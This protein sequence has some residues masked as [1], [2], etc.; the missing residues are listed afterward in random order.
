MLSFAARRATA[1]FLGAVVLMA[2]NVSVAAIPSSFVLFTQNDLAAFKIPTPACAAALGMQLQCDRA[3]VFGNLSSLNQ[4][5]ER[6]AFCNPKGACQQSIQALNLQVQKDCPLD[7]MLGPTANIA[8]ILRHLVLSSALPCAHDAASGANC[9]KQVKDAL[10][11]IDAKANIFDALDKNLAC[12]CFLAATLLRKPVDANAQQMLYTLR[13]RICGENSVQ[14]AVE[15]ILLPT[16]P[17]L[18]Y[19]PPLQPANSSM[20]FDAYAASPQA[21]QCGPAAATPLCPNGQ[22]CNLKG[23]CGSGPDFC[24]PDNCRYGYGP[25]THRTVDPKASK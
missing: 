25:C 4:D 21:E 10:S 19:V 23:L 13:T 3:A 14:D 2:A 16:I 6:A 5:A 11:K 12:G 18:P 20:T 8:Y 7:F 15:T 1:V 9:V 24:G 17:N 22:C